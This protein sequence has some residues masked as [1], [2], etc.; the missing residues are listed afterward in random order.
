[1]ALIHLKVDAR[2]VSEA[3]ELV[4]RMMALGIMVDQG[5]F[6]LGELLEVSGDKAGAMEAWSKALEY[7]SVAKSAAER[8]IPILGSQGRET[9]AK[10]LAK[11]YLKGC[12]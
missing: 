3:L 6:M 8:L 5:Q 7:P 2:K 4:R 1:M 9:E 12:C 11:K 10:F